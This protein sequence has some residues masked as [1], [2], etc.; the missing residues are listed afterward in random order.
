MDIR[1]ARYYTGGRDG[2]VECLLCPNHC[3]IADG[4]EGRCG[5]RR[6]SG[7]KLLA[8]SYGNTVAAAMDPVEKKPLYHFMP[9][10]DILSIGQNGCTLTCDHCQNWRISQKKAPVRYLS[11][12]DLV[13]LALRENSVG[14]A[15]TYT[16]PLLWLEYILDVI[17]LLRAR[18]LKSVLVTNGYLNEEPAREIVEAADAFNVDLKS[19]RNEFYR[20]W[21]GGS[22]EPVKRFI[23]LAAAHSHVEVTNLIIPGLNDS[24]GEIDELSSWLAGVSKD[25]PLHLSRFFPQHRMSDRQPTQP[26]KLEDAYHTARRYLDYVYVGNIFIEGTEDTICPECGEKV[27]RR[28]GYSVEIAMERGGCPAC[29]H[30]IKGVWN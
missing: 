22:V 9:G 20:A 24:A 3:V 29:G 16:E 1:E 5:L 15:F 21:C 25:I 6:N 12:E 14:V 23:E 28:S 2:A 4:A 7:G 18:K 30:R 10:T 26:S 27:I 19:I 8:E 11:P 17:P 13:S